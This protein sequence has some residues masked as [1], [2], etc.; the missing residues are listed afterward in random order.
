MDLKIGIDIHSNMLIPN[1]L[2]K[3]DLYVLVFELKN[4]KGQKYT[5][6]SLKMG[7]LEKFLS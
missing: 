2:K 6:K 7:F 1:P 4:F 5:K 3:L